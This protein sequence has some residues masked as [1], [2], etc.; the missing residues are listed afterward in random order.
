[1]RTPAYLIRPRLPIKLSDPSSSHQVHTHHATRRL[2]RTPFLLDILPNPRKREAEI[3]SVLPDD[4]KRYELVYGELKMMS[5]TGGLHGRVA[6][7]IGSM[8]EQHVRTNQLGE[9]FAAETG[10]LLST[11]PDTVRAPDAAFV[12]AHNFQG[13]DEVRE[14]LPVAPDLVVEVVSP[15]DSSSDVEEKANSWIR[16]GVRLVLVVDPA[17]RSIRAYRE[18]ASINVYFAGDHVDAADVVH[19]WRFAV[20]DVFARLLTNRPL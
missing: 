9:V 11:D 10:F 19:G 5:P 7:R 12:T 1:M 13:L 2:A 14:F 15:S 6:M 3:V 17:N 20:N 18:Q 8:L 4:G 16:F